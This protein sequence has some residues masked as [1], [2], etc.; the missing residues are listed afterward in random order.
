MHHDQER[1]LREARHQCSQA[2]RPIPG[3]PV[4]YCREAATEPSKSQQLVNVQSRNNDRDTER[5]LESERFEDM[6]NGQENSWKRSL[7]V[8]S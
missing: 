5:S 8:I 2:E 7:D 4:P 1:F 6:T 3:L